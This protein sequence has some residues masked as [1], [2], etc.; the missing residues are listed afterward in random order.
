ME[1]LGT[2]SYYNVAGANLSYP[3][4]SFANHS[5]KLESLSSPR[6]MQQR[7]LLLSE[8]QHSGIS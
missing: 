6:I 3:V 4:F 1:Y 8:D 2:E 5:S 7:T